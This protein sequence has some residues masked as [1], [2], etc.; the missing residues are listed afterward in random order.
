MKP[1]SLL[2]KY[3]S[4]FFYP[5]EIPALRLFSDYNVLQGFPC[6]ILPLL[7]HVHWCF[8]DFLI[9]PFHKCTLN[10]GNLVKHQIF[11]ISVA[12]KRSCKNG[13]NS[14][15][16]EFFNI[17][18]VQKCFL[19][20]CSK[21]LTW[22]HLYCVFTYIYSLMIEKDICDRWNISNKFLCV[23]ECLSSE[24]LFIFW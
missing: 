10:I 14:D 13:T 15:W 16:R 5:F 18:E 6:G 8:G 3:T 11:N 20:N 22:R 23:C 1:W 9:R 19:W 7:R 12:G 24:D 17:T 21:T 4:R 2:L